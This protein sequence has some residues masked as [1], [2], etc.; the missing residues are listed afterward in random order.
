M[1]LSP[2]GCLPTFL[3]RLALPDCDT[4][5]GAR[6]LYPEPAVTDSTD[7]SPADATPTTD[8]RPPINAAWLTRMRTL[9]PEFLTT[10]FTVFL[11]D[12]PKRITALGDAVCRVD[13]DT[14]RYLAHSIKG[15]AATLGMERLCEAARDLE[16]AAKDGQAEA[17]A[18]QYTKVLGE[19]EAVFEVMRGEP[20]L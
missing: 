19:M 10:L 7:T 17:L 8:T 15:A 5:C 16:H 6:T 2:P 4:G 13:L 12:E 9:K 20:E 1:G 3:Q 11:E 18:E 14:V